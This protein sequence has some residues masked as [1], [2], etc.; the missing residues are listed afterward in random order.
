V[1]VRQLL[2]HTSGIKDHLNEMHGK[3]CNG[4]SP[5]EITSYIGTLP[6]NFAPGSQWLYSN[7]GYLLL[8]IILQKVSGK[9]FDAFL[10][11]RMF[12]RSA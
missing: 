4:T 7:T 11:E 5:E 10:A 9:P 6:L 12:G 1:T 8:Q 3:T 2:S